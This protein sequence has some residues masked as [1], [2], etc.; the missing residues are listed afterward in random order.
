[1]TNE[2]IAKDP[3]YHPLEIQNHVFPGVWRYMMPQDFLNMNFPQ[4]RRATCMDC[5]K[6]AFE[7]YRPDYR[8]CTY[9]PRIP[10]FLLGLAGHSGSDEGRLAYI[11]EQGYATPEGMNGTPQQWIDYLDDLEH[12]RFG[13]SKKVLCPMLDQENGY[14]R[15]HAFRNSVCSTFFC[16]KDHGD[17]GDDFWSKVQTLGSQIEMALAQ[18][19]MEQLGFDVA[20]YIKRHN[21]LAKTIKS[22]SDPKTGGWSEA[23]RSHIWGKWYGREMEFYSRCGELVSEHREQLWDIANQS[24][25]LEASKFDKA[26]VKLVPKRLKDQ[27]D[28]EDL[29]EGE[30]TILP[31]QLWISL[32][33]SY[34]KLWKV[35]VQSYTLSKKVK[36]IPN[37]Q[38]DDVSQK[39]SDFPYVLCFLSKGEVDDRIFINRN[40]HDVL[41]KFE[42][43]QDMS[44]KFLADAYGD[45]YKKGK[46]FIA[47]MIG[48]KVLVPK[49]KR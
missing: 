47:E 23:A 26:M 20:A 2:K 6:S 1:M 13:S 8:C 4:E 31:Q 42:T 14:C 9:F 15:V 3:I 12:E 35:P 30:E 7:G 22:V 40:Q 48:Q 45:H 36:I 33:K 44:W 46:Q 29:E 41:K 37:E 25:I 16:Y 32:R 27:L 19:V 34:D 11:I 28:P 18:W 38:K 5:P 24:D 39:F 17:K 21:S 49:K 43:V 10:N